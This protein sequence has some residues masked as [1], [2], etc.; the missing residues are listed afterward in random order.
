[1]RFLQSSTSRIWER[2]GTLLRCRFA[3]RFS[4][5]SGYEIFLCCCLD[6][7]VTPLLVWMIESGIPMGDSAELM[8]QFHMPDRMYGGRNVLL[9]GSVP[10]ALIV[11]CQI[12]AFL[13]FQKVRHIVPADALRAD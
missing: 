1:M 4:T 10:V 5:Y 9:M 11:A 13:P 8:R 7:R 3:L 6:F 2:G 12:A